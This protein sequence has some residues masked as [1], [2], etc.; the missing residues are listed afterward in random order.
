MQV[1]DPWLVRHDVFQME[2]RM[3]I[4]AVRLCST[5]A[6][7]SAFLILAALQARKPRATSLEKFLGTSAKEVAFLLPSPSFCNAPLRQLLAHCHVTLQ[8]GLISIMSMPM[9][10]RP[11]FGSESSNRLASMGTKTFN[12]LIVL[13]EMGWLYCEGGWISWQMVLPVVILNLL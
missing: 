12:L 8:A 1:F 2:V 3:I 9:S 13:I 4:T 7:W 11:L 6:G 10:S 5:R